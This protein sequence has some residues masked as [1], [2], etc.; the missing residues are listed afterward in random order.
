MTL[1][2]H[3]DVVNT[4]KQHRF[5]VLCRLGCNKLF[6]ENHFASHSILDIAD[7][8]TNRRKWFHY[9]DEVP[10]IVFCASLSCYDEKLEEDETTV[11]TEA[12]S[13]RQQAS[14]LESGKPIFLYYFSTDNCLFALL[15]MC[16]SSL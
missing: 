2:Q 11:R 3:C 13:E 8:C 1:I 15:H 4:S 14:V 16:L 7:Q 12:D 6:Y 5:N 9:L 10:F